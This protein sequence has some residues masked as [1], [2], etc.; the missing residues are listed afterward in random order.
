MCF[1]VEDDALSRYCVEESQYSH[2]V[3]M[4]SE[5]NVGLER[6]PAWRWPGS[7]RV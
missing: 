3:M 2:T 6:G 5:V 4:E 7:K 1:K